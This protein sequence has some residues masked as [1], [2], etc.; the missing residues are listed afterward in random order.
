M[1]SITPNKYKLLL[2]QKNI[3]FVNDTFKIILMQSGF[4]FDRVNH[5]A[6]ADVSA[7]ELATA[8]GYT[9]G[10]AT[11]AGLVLAQDDVNNWAS[12]IWSNVVWTI[13]GGNITARGAIIYDDTVAAP[14]A[15]PIIGYIDFLTD[16]VTYDGGTMTVANPTIAT[17]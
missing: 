5:D 16:L 14:T 2:M 9:A 3:D 8:Y 10:G 7:N 15:K 17:L 11:L 6:Y 12:A 4:S 1:A 13:T